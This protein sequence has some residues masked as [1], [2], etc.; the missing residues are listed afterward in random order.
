MSFLGKTEIKLVLQAEY[1]LLQ[2]PEISSGLGFRC[3]DICLYMM[4]H[5]RNRIEV[6]IQKFIQFI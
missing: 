2:M 6:K 5:H 3:W 1:P 4:R